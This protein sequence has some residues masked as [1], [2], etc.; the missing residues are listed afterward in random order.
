M[1]KTL[2]FKVFC[3]E[4]YKSAHNLTGCDAVKLFK[5]FGVLEY[6]DKFYDVLHTTGR[7]YLIDDIDEFIKIRS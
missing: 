6:L 4:A 7:D 2:Q 5:K 1:S 3:I